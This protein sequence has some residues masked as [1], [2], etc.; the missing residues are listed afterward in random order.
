MPQEKAAGEPG[1]AAGNPLTVN[2]IDAAS[3]RR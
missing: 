2:R 1:A 3:L